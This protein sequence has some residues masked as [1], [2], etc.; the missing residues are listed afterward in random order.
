MILLIDGYNV[1]RFLY[2]DSSAAREEY[3]LLFFKKL[4]RY[5]RLKKDV[6]LEIRVVL[7]G[8]L[9]SHKTREVRKGIVV[10]QSGH[11]RK[12]DDVLVE[13]GMQLRSQAVVVTN[14]RELQR[15]LKEH[16][17]N[18]VSVTHF[19]DMVSA[20]CM[21]D[22]VAQDDAHVYD[23]LVITKYGDGDDEHYP[24][25]D[26]LMI[27]GSVLCQKKI[28]DGE[29]NAKKRSSSSVSKKDKAAQFV[30]RKLG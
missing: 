14:D 8:G 22:D 18:V 21:Q 19:W 17:C 28:D 10:I 12:A 6:L 2:P 1:I 4:A 23:E 13:Y 9:F 5:W 15:R 20:L 11:K 27:E 16:S 30:R 24:D 26:D 29:E 25:I 7:D 3:Q